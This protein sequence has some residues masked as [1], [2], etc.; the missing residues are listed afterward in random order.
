MQHLCSLLRNFLGKVSFVTVYVVRV[1]V[2]TLLSLGLSYGGCLSIVHMTMRSVKPSCLSVS[3]HTRPAGPAERFTTKEE[4]NIEE[5]RI[6]VVRVV[7]E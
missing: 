7:R 2:Q 6:L 3:A 1:C 5:D 4:N